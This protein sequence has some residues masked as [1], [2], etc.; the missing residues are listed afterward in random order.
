LLHDFKSII[1]IIVIWVTTECIY[2]IIRLLVAVI[3]HKF[4]FVLFISFP[5]KLVEVDEEPN[6]R[7]FFLIKCH[8]A[9]LYTSF[10]RLALSSPLLRVTRYE[11]EKLDIVSAEI[12]QNWPLQNLKMATNWPIVCSIY[13]LNLSF[14]GVF[15]HFSWWKGC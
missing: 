14:Q 8:W 10:F 1:N 2:L 6:R 11:N 15:L 7:Y 13:A 4:H 3:A 12:C 9:H 5:N